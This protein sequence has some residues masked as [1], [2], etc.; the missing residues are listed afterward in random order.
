MFLLSSI[1]F[2][3]VAVALA[4]SNPGVST[5]SLHHEV[6]HNVVRADDTVSSAWYTGWHA[7]S[8]QPFTL[9]NVPWDKYTHVMYAF[10]ET[11]EDPSDTSLP[12]D[13]A[14]LLP[15]FVS[16]AHDNGVKALLSIGGWTGSRF[17]S[18]NVGDKTNRTSFVNAIT[19][20]VN[21]YKLDGIDFAWNYPGF[22]G[23]G[24]NTISPNDTANL[25]S[26][27]Q[28]LR[29]TENGSSLIL[30]AAT[31]L[32]PF[33]DETGQPSTNVSAFANVLDFIEIMNYDVFGNWSATAGPNSPLNDTCTS[34]EHQQGCAVSAVS[35]WT[36]AGMPANKIVLGV[37][38]F[39][40]SFTVTQAAAL[41]SD[42]STDLVLYPAF[43]ASVFP[44]GDAW[45]TPAHVDKCGNFADQ[46]GIQHFRYLVDSGMLFPNGTAETGIPYLFD[47]CEKT[48]Y[49]YNMTSGVLISYD[50]PRAFT[51]AGDFI[52]TSGLRGFA[53][54]EAGGDKDSVLLDA[55]RSGVG[56]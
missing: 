15:Q 30:T 36:A 33:T 6:I 12:D 5:N 1:C 37:A 45:D 21:T 29:N 22:Q 32:V 38:T 11:T 9:D 27:L 23:I 28:E 47:D 48:D 18:S 35:S 7:Q 10:R 19:K 41:A 24:C 52:Q 49:V 2:L 8:A 13:D 53:L 54:W 51:A 31:R 17:Y 44:A 50:G 4:R 43:N 25:L 20:L 3:A 14:S 46:G 16:K 55:I 26:T 40:H 39:G 34:A 42:S 56:L